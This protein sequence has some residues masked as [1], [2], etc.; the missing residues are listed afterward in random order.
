MR[1]E[2]LKAGY[3][4]SPLGHNYS[5]LQVLTIEGL[6]NKTERPIYP[7]VSGGARTFKKATREVGRNTQR[8]LFGETM[9]LSGQSAKIIDPLRIAAGDDR[10]PPRRVD[11]MRLPGG[12][13]AGSRKA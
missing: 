13:K 11:R 10:K 8:D 2:A 3:Y 9:S 1:S 7:D 4:S 5:K 12:R 6:L